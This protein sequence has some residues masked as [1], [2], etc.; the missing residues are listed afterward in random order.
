MKV[1]FM[2]QM[3]Y[4]C[5]LNIR[6]LI[7]CLGLFLWISLISLPVYAQES[8]IIHSVHVESSC[9]DLSGNKAAQIAWQI[10]RF[11]LVSVYI[12]DLDG[13]LIRTLI[14]KDGMAAGEHQVA[15]DG[16]DE[17]GALCPNGAYIPIIKIKARDETAEIYNPTSLSWGETVFPKDLYYDFDRKVVHYRLERLALCR[18]RIGEYDGGPLY[19]TLIDWKPRWAD[20]H[21]EPWDGMDKNGVVE[22][23]KKKKHYIV[24]EAFSLPENS[25]IVQGSNSIGP[26]SATSHSPFA[27]HSAHGKN[28]NAHATHARDG[29]H[30]LLI[31]ARISGQDNDLPTHIPVLK[32]PTSIKVSVNNN[33]DAKRLIK[34][35][36]ELYLYIDGLFLYEILPENLPALLKLNTLTYQNGEH[37]LTINARTMED[38]VGTYSMKISIENK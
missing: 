25:I 3:P 21:D 7:L 38:H 33:N 5:Y 28:I 14:Q 6:N 17:V 10:S 13:K 23:T 1:Y 24:L 36:L 16:R 27:I 12:C 4:K 15:W 8:R 22:I 32:G 34:K 20:V 19:R 37:V 2:K 11:S 31:S 9:I 18:I 26:N 30:E 35:G 29:C